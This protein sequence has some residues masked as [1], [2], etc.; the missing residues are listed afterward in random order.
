MACSLGRT[1]MYCTI[2]AVES[3][4]EEEAETTWTAAGGNF[5]GIPRPYLTYLSIFPSRGDVVGW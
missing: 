1:T 2:H 4:R 5:V 3:L